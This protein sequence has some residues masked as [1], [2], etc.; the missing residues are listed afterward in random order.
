MRISYGRMARGFGAGVLALFLSVTAVR[1]EFDDGGNG[2]LGYCGFYEP[3]PGALL[4]CGGWCVVGT[5][6]FYFNSATGG[7]NCDCK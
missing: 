6:T 3:Y 7:Y 5:C 1:A 4:R 2:F